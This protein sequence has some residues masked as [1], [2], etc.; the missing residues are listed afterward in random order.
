MRRL[1]SVLL[2]LAA[3]T[4]T[5]GPGAGALPRRPR[6]RP[7]SRSQLRQARTF[8]LHQLARTDRR[9]GAG[10]FPTVAVPGRP[11]RTSGTDG[12]LAGF[13][14]GRLWLAYQADGRPAWAR[15]AAA[16]QAPLA[17][18]Q[19]DTTAHDLGFLLQTSF[20]RGAVLAGRSQDAAVVRRAARRAGHPLRAVGRRRSAAGTA[21]P[22][23]SPSTST[24]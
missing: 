5:A 6:T 24:T 10:R 12:W 20:G 7:G 9:L 14:P 1:G 16:R 18:R 11:W 3:L 21:R 15:R 19:D 2:A 13:W 17:V 23:R 8:A 22:G 4:G